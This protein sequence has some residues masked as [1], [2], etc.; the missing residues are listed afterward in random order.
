[1][2]ELRVYYIYLVDSLCFSKLVTGALKCGRVELACSFFEKAQEQ[3]QFLDNSLKEKLVQETHKSTLEN[4]RELI[5]KLEIKKSCNNS[6]YS[7][8][9]ESLNNSF[10]PYQMKSNE[11]S[12]ISYE[13]KGFVNSFEKKPF[14]VLNDNEKENYSHNSSKKENVLKERMKN[15]RPREFNPFNSQQI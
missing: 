11:N 6:F 10:R 9:S 1:M 8:K 15:K 4:K 7:K 14:K 2:R 12:Q 3:N 5:A 13:K